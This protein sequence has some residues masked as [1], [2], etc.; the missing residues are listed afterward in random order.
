MM[1]QQIARCAALALFALLFAIPALGAEVTFT[2]EVVY[3]ER[4]ALPAGSVLT[5]ALVALPGGVPVASAQAGLDQASSPIA[6]TLDVHSA[7]RAAGAYGLVAEIRTGQGVFRTPQ[8]VPVD[9]AAPAG[10]VIPVIFGPAP[11]PP[12]TEQSLPALA[13]PSDLVDTHWLVTSIGGDPVMQDTELTFSIAPDHRAGGNGGCNSYFAEASFEEKG[14]AFGPI[15][16]TRMACAEAIMAQET[17][18]FAALDATRGYEVSGDA[19]KLLDAAGVT[20]MG[21]VRAP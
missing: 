3:R 4:L 16:G 1:L 21:L 10:I 14:L 20:L 9:L 18:F 19:L 5:V 12:S 6:F 2:G 7:L 17:R 11:P 8:P 15:A 13:V